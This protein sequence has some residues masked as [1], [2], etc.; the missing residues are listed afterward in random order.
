M[1]KKILLSLTLIISTTFNIQSYYYYSPTYYYPTYSYPTYTPTYTYPTYY[2]SYSNTIIVS[3]IK[4]RKPHEHLLYAIQ[5]SSFSSFKSLMQLYYINK[6]DLPKTSLENLSKKT[7][8]KL[9]NTFSLIKDGIAKANTEQLK[10]LHQLILKS[11][12]ASLIG[13]GL[14]FSTIAT[15]LGSVLLQRLDEYNSSEKKLFAAIILSWYCF[16]F[17]KIY[18]GSINYKERIQKKIHQNELISDYIESH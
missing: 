10:K 7:I 1:S 9:Y 11:Y 3:K 16:G 6:A 2:P 18:D 12:D 17:K 13:A 8:F 14:A 15:F 5:N 4:R